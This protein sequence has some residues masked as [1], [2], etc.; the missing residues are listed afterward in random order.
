[1]RKTLTTLAV[2]AAAFA[3]PM[4]G[5]G[6]AYADTAVNTAALQQIVATGG[7]CTTTYAAAV[8]GQRIG[9]VYNVTGLTVTVYG[10]TPVAYAGGQEG[11]T[12]AFENCVV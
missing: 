12:L 3:V 6:T 4:L 2:T 1:M 8:E 7:G 9:P 5:A 10:G 11:N